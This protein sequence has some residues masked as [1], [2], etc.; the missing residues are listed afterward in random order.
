MLD[1]SGQTP[2]S[3]RIGPDG[4]RLRWRMDKK[5]IETT[6]DRFRPM[7]LL[8]HDGETPRVVWRDLKDIPLNL[9]FFFESVKVVQQAKGVAGLFQ[10]DVEVVKQ[11][12]AQPGGLAFSG[13]MFHMARTGSTLVHRLLSA[14]GKV[15][16]LSEAPIFNLALAQGSKLPKGAQ[17]PVIRALLGAYARPR[18]PTD[19][20]M[21][22]KMQDVPSRELPTFREA[23]PE[24]PWIFIYRDPVEVMVSLIRKPTGTMQQWYHN[25]ARIAKTLEM[26]GLADG[27][28][29]PPDY[30]ARTLRKFCEA[31]VEA[32]KVAPKGNFLAINYRRL[33]EAVWETIGP[34]FG[35][36]FTGK[37]IDEM[38]EAAKYSSKEGG[39]KEFKSDVK[40]KHDE[41]GPRVRMLADKLIAPVLRQIEELPQG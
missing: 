35:I 36:E 20:H 9:P 11:V 10:T 5:I 32:A 16:S 41:A 40:G 37:E 6:F 26:P 19:Q 22:I 12:A 7:Q 8:V 29:S 33:P 4:P 24:T 13:A 1:L 14:S 21:V 30:A 3:V 28:L 34:H 39:A 23:F 25:R 18:R 15:H 2:L 38:R 27:S 17:A 31:A